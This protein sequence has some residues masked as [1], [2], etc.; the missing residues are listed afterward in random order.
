MDVTMIAD[1]FGVDVE[2]DGFFDEENIVHFVLTPRP[3]MSIPFVIRGAVMQPGE[4]FKIL[5]L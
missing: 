5:N 4:V 3:S 1:F 2:V